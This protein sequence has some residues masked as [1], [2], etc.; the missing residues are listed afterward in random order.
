MGSAGAG[1]LGKAVNSQPVPFFSRV[2]GSGSVPSGILRQEDKMAASA[3]DSAL[4]PEDLKPAV[5]G[6]GRCGGA[7]G[8]GIFPQALLWK[9][10]EPVSQKALCL[11]GQGWSHDQH[12]PQRRLGRRVLGL[13][14]S[15]W[16]VGQAVGNRHTEPQCSL[17]PLHLPPLKYFVAVRP[18]FVSARREYITKCA[19]RKEF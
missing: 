1:S 18:L 3:S 13:L 19:S 16:E 7:A 10:G 8:E 11:V 6:G 14:A 2:C 5:L 9:Q 15:G 17:Y 4:A 12:W